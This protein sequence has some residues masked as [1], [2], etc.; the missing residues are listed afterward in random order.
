MDLGTMKQKLGTGKY[1]SL[2][3]ILRDANLV[4]SNCRLFNA[5]GS[6]IY[7]A[8]GEVERHFNQLWRQQ[9]LDKLMVGMQGMCFV[10]SMYARDCKKCTE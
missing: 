8:C 9:G 1:T 5:A 6:D 10:L 3:A 2:G 4:W 7:I